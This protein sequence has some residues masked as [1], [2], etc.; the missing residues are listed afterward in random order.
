MRRS[1]L[2]SIALVLIGSSAAFAQ[3]A[4]TAG[5]ANNPTPEQ[6]AFFEKKIRPVLVDQCYKCHSA[7]A[8]QVKGELHLDT[9]AGTRKGGLSGAIIVPGNAERSLLIKALHSKDSDTAMPPKGKL[10]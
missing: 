6:L 5:F 3:P 1:A 2:T 8:E 4:K 9:R 10:P 7:D